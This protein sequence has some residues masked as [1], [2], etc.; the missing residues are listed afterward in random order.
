MQEKEEQRMHAA[1]LTRTE[2]ATTACLIVVTASVTSRSS[3]WVRH[4]EQPLMARV[5]RQWNH[6]WMGAAMPGSDC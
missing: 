4:E 2:H 5:K 1:W 6:R 3:H